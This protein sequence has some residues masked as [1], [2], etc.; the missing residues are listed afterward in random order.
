MGFL[1]YTLLNIYK[2]GELLKTIELP[3]DCLHEAPWNPNRMD[4][5][6][7]GRLK[8]SL[9]RYG[10]VQP[11]VVR[12]IGKDKYEVLSGNHRLRVFHDIGKKTVPCIIVNLKDTESMLLAEALNGIRGDDDLALKGSLLKK[13]LAS[14][15]TDKVLALLPETAESLQA[16]STIGQDDLGEHLKAWQKA[17]AARLKHMQL[18]FSSDQL[19][20]VEKALDMVVAKAKNSINGNPN[21]RGTAIYLLARYYLERNKRK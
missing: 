20:T 10:L 4:D 2:G 9:S 15:P 18:Q 19:E 12:P 1:P 17:Q 6:S 7:Y 14:I 11:L 8:Q 13:I 5:A 21:I 16:L 3:I